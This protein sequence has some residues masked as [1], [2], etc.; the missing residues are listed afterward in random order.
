[1]PPKKIFSY[2]ELQQ[3]S[4]TYSA[5]WDQRVCFEGSKYAE[6]NNLFLHCKKTFKVV[7]KIKL[8]SY[9]LS[10]SFNKKSCYWCFKGITNNCHCAQRYAKPYFKGFAFC[11]LF[12]LCTTHTYQKDYPFWSQNKLFPFCYISSLSLF[13]AITWEHICYFQRIH[14]PVILILNIDSHQLSLVLN[15]CTSLILLRINWSEYD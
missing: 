13:S 14:F 10:E 12:Q 11:T 15:F 2:S 8:F 3:K 4:R 7:L 6:S 9:N 5:A 1:M